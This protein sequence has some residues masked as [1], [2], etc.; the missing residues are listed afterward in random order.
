M[1]LAYLATF[2][3][4]VSAHAF[5]AAVTHQQTQHWFHIDIC[6]IPYF[7]FDTNIGAFALRWTDD[8]DYL[9]HFH[10]KREPVTST[11]FVYLL[12]ENMHW[13]WSSGKNRK[14]TMYWA[15]L[16]SSVVLNFVPIWL[17][18]QRNWGH[19]IHSKQRAGYSFLQN[20]KHCKV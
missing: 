1:Y 16:T 17:N 15:S 12:Y 7:D 18:I 14:P 3:N 19:V 10:F 13:L 2:F 4:V 6:V 11:M 5:A 9:N 8:H 20:W